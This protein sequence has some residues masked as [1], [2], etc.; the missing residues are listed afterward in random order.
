MI[1]IAP[2]LAHNVQTFFADY[3]VAQRDTSGHTVLAY[4]DALKLFLTFIARGRKKAVADLGFEDIAP[5]GV[6]AFLEDIEKRRKNSVRTRNARLA[7]LHTFFRYVAA[8]EPQLLD[9]CQRISGIPIKKTS[10]PTVVYIEHAELL[11]VLAHIDRK[12]PRGRRDYLLLRLLFETGARAQEMASVRTSALQ[13]ERPSKMRLL[14]KGR[15]ER[16]CPLRPETVPY[17]R[18][19]LRERGVAVGQDVPLF[20]GRHGGALTRFGILRIVQR[21]VRKASPSLPSLARKNVG[22][23]TF[24]HAA[25]LHLLRAGNELSVVKSWLG[26]VSI[27]TTDLYM[28]IDDEMKRK[29]IEATEPVAAPKRQPIWKRDRDLLAWLEAL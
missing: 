3:L 25:A 5:E 10:T 28:E 4:R 23:H 27:V 24:R 29:A 12:T 17:I 7:A 1:P 20:V 14:G 6:L 21:H 22:A 15:K 16:I 8:R 18:E 13:L 26:H 9:L 11:H 19:H 2:S